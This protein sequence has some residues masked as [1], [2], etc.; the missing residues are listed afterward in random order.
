[1]FKEQVDKELKLLGLNL[2]K[3]PIFYNCPYGIRFEIGIGDVYGKNMIPR[4]EYVKN[5][6]RRAMTI[7]NNGIKSLGILMWE[8]YSQPE[9]NKGDFQIL[10]SERI[11]PILPQEE[12]LKDIKSDGDIMKKIEFYWDLKKCKI[13]INKVFTEIIL[14][15]LGGMQEFVA[16][17]YLFDIQNHIMLHLYD[18]RGLDIVA[19]DKNTL[20]SFYKKLNTWI[21][22]YDRKQTDKI[23]L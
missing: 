10:F 19:H 2:L 9:R 4:K 15:D 5:A 18:D 11:T 13:P 17:V 7:Y 22:Y 21:L 14:G 3:Q 23:F 16:S 6:L 20:I 1:M 12:Y 8:V